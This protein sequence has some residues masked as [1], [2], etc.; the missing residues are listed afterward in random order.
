MRRSILAALGT[1]A[2]AVSLVVPL[3][4][5]A[6]AA[7]PASKLNGRI[8]FS[9]DTGIASMNPDGSGQWGGRTLLPGDTQPAWSPDGTMLAVVTRGQGAGG[10][11]LDNPDGSTI[12]MLTRDPSDAH[13]TW[14]P[15]G[16]EVAFVDNGTLTVVESDGSRRRSLV[17]TGYANSPTWSPDGTRIAFSAYNETGSH[18]F[19]LDLASG[20][21]T[22]VTTTTGGSDSSPA[23]SPDGADIAFTSYRDGSAIWL[24]HPDSSDE[25][26]VTAA[27]VYDQSPAWAPDGSRIAFLRAGDIWSVGR[28]GTDVRQLTTGSRSMYDSAPAWQPLDPGPEACTLWGTSGP[29]LLVGSEGVDVLCG[30]DGNDTLVGLGGD[31]RLEGGSGSD[32]MA[33]GSGRDLLLGGPGRDRLDARDGAPDVIIGG[34][35]PGDHA[36]YDK[37]MDTAYGVR[38]RQVSHNIAVW[39]PVT[40]SGST[41]TNPPV[42]AVDGR[43]DDVWNS[44]GSAPQ[45]I[46]IDLGR[47]R[48]I[49]R[50]RLIAGDQ[51]AGSAVLVLAR[52]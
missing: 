7:A 49:G 29:D 26:R 12:R 37:G 18:I 15:D 40:A 10:I 13:P 11:R 36:L 42:R 25:R 20:T 6:T 38:I 17:T 4:S 19:A 39:R 52:R 45:S 31:D 2:L 9:V 28:D 47:P 41:A 5:G 21:Q 22:Q 8:A 16:K 34:D 14:S 32:W 24:I 35:D 48:S 43:V 1:V 46:E 33:G 44:G 30:L 3:D 27:G 51:P 23:W 50:I